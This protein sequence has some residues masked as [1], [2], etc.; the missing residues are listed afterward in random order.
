VSQVQI[1]QFGAVCR[2]QTSHEVHKNKQLSAATYKTERLIF[3][4][5]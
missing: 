1:L 5:P 2:P 4:I 3:C